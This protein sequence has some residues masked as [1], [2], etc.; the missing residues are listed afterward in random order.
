[1]A[2]GKIWLLAAILLFSPQSRAYQAAPLPTDPVL[3]TAETLVGKALFLR[4]FYTSQT[5]FSIFGTVRFQF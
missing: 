1:M 2:H 5:L 3:V 4:N